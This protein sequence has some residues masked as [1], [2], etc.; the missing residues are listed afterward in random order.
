MKHNVFE[1]LLCVV[2]TLI[3]AMSIST[4]FFAHSG[5]IDSNGGHYV[6]ATGEYHYHHGYP[7]HQH[8]NGKCPYEKSAND[9]SY[10][11]YKST[12]KGQKNDSFLAKFVTACIFA[13][14]AIYPFLILITM[15]IYKFAN[16][17]KN[18]WFPLLKIWIISLLASVGIYQVFDFTD[19]YIVVFIAI[20]FYLIMLLSVLPKDDNSN[21]NHNSNMSN[22]NTK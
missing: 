13:T 18:E 6:S 19:A 7:A 11:E 16:V 2:V 17:D 12:Y 10:E 20:I 4:V 9:A 5:N 21:S 1:R 14:F 8:P 3:T 15:I 22:N